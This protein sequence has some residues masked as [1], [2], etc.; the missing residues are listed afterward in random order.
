MYIPGAKEKAELN[1]DVNKS[2]LKVAGAICHPSDEGILQSLTLGE[3]KV[4]L[5]D[6]YTK[7][8][9]EGFDQKKEIS[10]N[11]TPTKFK[12]GILVVTI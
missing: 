2:N 9:I 6:R 10:E 1:W 5:F 3:S 12:Y 7:S 4:R 8:T 11:F